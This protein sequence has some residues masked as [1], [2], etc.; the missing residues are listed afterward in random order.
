MGKK[1]VRGQCR[2]GLFFS[3]KGLKRHNGLISINVCLFYKKQIFEKIC[4]SI[5]TF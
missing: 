5:K 4:F 2:K 1:I 3:Q